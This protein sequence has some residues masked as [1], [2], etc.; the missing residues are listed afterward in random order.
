M[1]MTP[2]I[3]REI[4]TRAWRAE[5]EQLQK[6]LEVRIAAILAVEDTGIGRAAM[7]NIAES[8]SRQMVD[9]LMINIVQS[10]VMDEII[11]KM[12]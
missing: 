4:L 1:A 10:G 5:F 7:I 11:R 6:N 3:L 12:L 8:C 2:D 9:A